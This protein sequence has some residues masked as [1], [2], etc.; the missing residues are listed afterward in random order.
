MSVTLDRI[1]AEY[2]ATDLD[3]ATR[4][5]AEALDVQGQTQAE[6]IIAAKQKVALVGGKLRRVARGG[7]GK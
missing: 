1:A 2:M 4:L 6:K 7:R 3:I 5:L